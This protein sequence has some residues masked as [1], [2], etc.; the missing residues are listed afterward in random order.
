MSGH[1]AFLN[2]QFW[3]AFK[4]YR[5]ILSWHGILADEVLGDMALNS[6]LNR[7]MAIGLGVMPDA[8]D[9]VN[10]MNQIVAALPNVWVRHAVIFKMGL[11]RFA[12]FIA[13]F[14]QNNKSCK[15][16]S[17]KLLRSIGADEDADALNRK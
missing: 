16:D 9:A 10:K 15:S 6:L 1:V 4:L 3:G 5:N 11:D 13:M 8:N 14:A 7:Y 17:V 2:R 12:K